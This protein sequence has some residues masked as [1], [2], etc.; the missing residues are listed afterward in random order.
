M[1]HRH[2]IPYPEQLKK[3]TEW[4]G[5]FFVAFTLLLIHHDQIHPGQSRHDQ[6]PHDQSHH[7]KNH[8]L[9][10]VLVKQKFR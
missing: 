3:I 7:H 4:V 6:S 10:H 8:G 1:F 5:D 9:Q 2:T